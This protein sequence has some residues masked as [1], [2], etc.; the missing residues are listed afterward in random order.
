M[1]IENFSFT[2]TTS[3]GR[4]S[5]EAGLEGTLSGIFNIVGLGGVVSA[6]PGMN[7]TQDEENELNA[8]KTQL[9]ATS[10]N[11]QNKIAAMNATIDKDRIAILQSMITTNQNQQAVI[12]E[13]LNE[14]VQ[15]NSLM[16]G[17]LTILVFFLI[18]YDLV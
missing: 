3:C 8:A 9:A 13:T 4:G 6:I 7:D 16:I 12:D 11:W 18:V 15:T 1:T 14:K 10:L 2:A 17:M 5:T